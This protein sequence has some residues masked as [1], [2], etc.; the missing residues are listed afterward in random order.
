MNSDRHET[1]RKDFTCTV[2]GCNGIANCGQSD[3]DLCWYGSCRA[4]GKSLIFAPEGC[5][6]GRM[7]VPPTCESCED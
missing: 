3:A 4:C 1:E 7:F 2:D 6:P 5:K